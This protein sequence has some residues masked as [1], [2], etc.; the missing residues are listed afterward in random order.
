VVVY[1]LLV[2]VVAISNSWI[3]TPAH[4]LPPPAS[5]PLS[6]PALEVVAQTRPRVVLLGMHDAF[7]VEAWRAVE[8]RTAAELRALGLDVRR[9]TARAVGAEARVRELRQAARQARAIGALRIAR[10]DG[11]HLVQLW[12]YD[13]LTQK[14]VMH[15][16]TVAD[17]GGE[18]AAAVVA[19]RLVGLL[20]ASLLE[21]RMRGRG[22]ARPTKVPPLV[23]KLVAQRLEPPRPRHPGRWQ[24]WGGPSVMLVDLGASPGASLQL[25]GGWRPVSWL[26]LGLE[27]AFP[28]S[29]SLVDPD[30][31]RGEAHVMAFAAKAL[32]RVEPWVDL[33][34]SPGI[35]L[36]A[37]IAALRAEGQATPP[38]HAS[39]EW[40]ATALF[41]LRLRLAI[42][43]GRTHLVPF[44][45]LGALLPKAPVYFDEEPV[46]D[47]GLPLI[48][49]GALVQWSWP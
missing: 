1:R 16:T 46:V 25:G 31:P 32:A 36:G 40:T 6:M 49:A 34:A 30:D 27:A 45:S 17:E 5:Q 15:E 9:A 7:P 42:R 21:L 10:R 11:K 35:E 8:R 14:T 3:A 37:G 19:F 41:V 18:D 24:L 44:F 29:W 2:A 47:L 13:A 4:A 12:V 22:R 20:H 38:H 26:L 43:L 48:E 33:R 28:L 39:A 23:H